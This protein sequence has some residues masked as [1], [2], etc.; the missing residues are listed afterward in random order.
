M[1]VYLHVELGGSCLPRVPAPF[2]DGHI[3]ESPCPLGP[4]TFSS[5]TPRDD[6]QLF[7]YDLDFDSCPIPSLIG[8]SIP[9]SGTDGAPALPCAVCSSGIE[10]CHEGF[11]VLCL[12][13]QAE[14]T[15][16]LESGELVVTVNSC[17]NKWKFQGSC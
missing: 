14:E 17:Y 11:T 8:S 5:L 9:S 2:P 10:T 15:I 16:G 1:C 12:V 3:T 4:L 13:C 6:S 7:A